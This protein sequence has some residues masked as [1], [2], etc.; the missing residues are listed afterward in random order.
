MDFDFDVELGL[1]LFDGDRESSDWNGWC[2]GAPHAHLVLRLFRTT[3]SL[4]GRRYYWS[5][6]MI[7]DME[8]NEAGDQQSAV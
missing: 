3:P 7:I 1:R 5:K 8:S 4:H 6:S 2:Y